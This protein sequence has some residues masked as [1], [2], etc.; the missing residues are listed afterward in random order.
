MHGPEPCRTPFAG[1]DGPYCAIW[2]CASV[3]LLRGI[4]SRSLR[5][6]YVP[7]GRSVLLSRHVSLTGDDRLVSAPSAGVVTTVEHGADH[8]IELFV[9]VR[10]LQQ[11]D[12][13]RL[14]TSRKLPRSF[15]GRQAFARPDCKRPRSSTLSGWI[16]SRSGSPTLARLPP[17]S[18]TR[19]PKGRSAPGIASL[20]LAPTP[21]NSAWL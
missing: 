1:G 4:A 16:H 12:L 8:A 21:G 17:D 18:E 2:I 3:P 5:A 9:Q 6:A 14:L 19:S 20:A 13:G 11:S 7:L 15:V 10:N